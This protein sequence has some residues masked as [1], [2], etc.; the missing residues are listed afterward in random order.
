MAPSTVL[1]TGGSSLSGMFSLNSGRKKGAPGI[2][3]VPRLWSGGVRKKSEYATS[4]R[5]TGASRA[6]SMIVSAGHVG[7]AGPHGPPP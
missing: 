7:H 2:G 1:V 4:G 5:K 6:T 3:I